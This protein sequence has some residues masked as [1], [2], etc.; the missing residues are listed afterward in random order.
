[1]PSLTLRARS[2]AFAALAAALIAPAA[3]AQQTAAPQIPAAGLTGTLDKIAR[4]GTVTLGYREASVPFSFVDRAGKPIGYSMDL[5][6]AIVEEIGRTLGRDDLKVAYEKVTSETRLQAV[7]DGKVDLEC[8]STTANLERAKIVSFSPLIFVAGTKVMVAK[9][10]PWKD[11][12]SLKGKTVAVTAGTTNIAALKKLDEKFQLGLKLVE[13]PDHEQSYQ[14]LA[15]G[16]VD[17]FATDDILLAGLIAQHRAQDKFMVA[18]ELLSYDPY[19]IAYRHDDKPMKQI[20]ERA[21]RAL[22]ISNEIDPTYEKWFG[23]RLP[24]GER[25]NIPMSPQLEESWKAFATEIEPDQK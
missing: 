25:F 22:V 10:T 2:L 12:N 19:G 5:C 7:A 16:K 23:H 20:I 1:M 21:F 18:G 3:F 15:S 9:G 6:N 17:A 24:N 14:L 8:G 4:T 11:F 13:S